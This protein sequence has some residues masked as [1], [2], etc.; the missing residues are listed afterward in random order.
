M[1]LGI[2]TGLKFIKPVYFLYQFRT[3]IHWFLP[4]NTGSVPIATCTEPCHTRYIRYRYPLL[5]ISVPVFSVPVGNELIKS[6]SNAAMQ[7]ANGIG[8]RYRSQVYQTGVFLVPVPHRYSPVF[9]LKYRFRTNTD[10]YQT[11]PY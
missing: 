6:S 9:T 8:H 3:G 4:S 5:V 1:V 11:V 7:V 2:G 10:L